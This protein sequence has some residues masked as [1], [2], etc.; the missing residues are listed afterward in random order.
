MIRLALSL[1]LTLAAAPALAAGDPL[2]AVNRQVHAFNLLAQRHLLGP[3]AQAY[4]AWTPAPV[5]HGVANALANLGEPVTAAS[6]MLAGDLT[7]ATQAATRF[8]INTALGYGGLRDAAAERGY[9]PIRMGVADALCR[10]GIPSGPYLVLPLLGPST[11]RDAGA[12]LATSLALSHALGTDTVLTWSA[13]AAWTEY[14]AQHP[15]L[16]QATTQALDSYA[17]WRSI[18]RQRR[19]G[20]CGLDGDGE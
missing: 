16:D 17:T 12:T 4:T 11:L 19:A 15:A 1:A 14:A 20:A 5:R 10:W 6:A 2:E 18:Y 3:M 9:P 7:L 13:A 8:G